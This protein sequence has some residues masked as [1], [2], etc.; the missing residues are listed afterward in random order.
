MRCMH[1]GE[2]MEDGA[3]PGAKAGGGSVRLRVGVSL[4]LITLFLA[5]GAG[6]FLLLYGLRTPPARAANGTPAVSVEVL[7]LRRGEHLERISGY[8]RARVL[9][10]TQV[11]AEVGG[12]VVW[13]HPELEAG[14]TI[15]SGQVLVRLDDRDLLDALAIARARLAQAETAKSRLDVDEVAFSRQRDLTREELE[16]AR[17]ELD[18]TQDLFSRGLASQSALD[19]QS[20]LVKRLERLEAELAWRVESVGADR[21]RAEAEIAAQTAAVQQ[22]VH[23][24]ERAAI[25]APYPARVEARTVELGAILAPGAVVCRVVD[26][27]RVEVPVALPAS[28]FGEV[29]P[30]AGVRLRLGEGGPVVW[31][32]TITRTSPGID[33][34]DRTFR[35]YCEVAGTSA[36][37][38]A[39]VPDGAFVVAEV[40]GRLFTQVIPCPRTAFVGEL[41][42]VAVPAPDGAD[43]GGGGSATGADAVVQ[44]RRPRVRRWLPE[45][46][47]VES[48]LSPGELVVTSNLE[49][50]GGG[51]RVQTMPA[52]VSL[53]ESTAQATEARRDTAVDAPAAE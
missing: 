31:E 12:R 16:I 28:R 8:G 11:A 40:D 50:V 47:L 17:G 4:L 25:R 2:V 22:A 33:A 32:G 18:R 10:R 13:V 19:Q 7:V 26:P 24:H 9:R 30:G 41:V 42:Y 6:A 15:Q 52:D 53:D 27:S 36:G 51:T 3:Q 14:A 23:N 5:V 43:A 48:G 34:R 39:P 38:S 20:Q 46:A 1:A 49:R 44:E 29:A 45:V 37:A 21:A 35:A